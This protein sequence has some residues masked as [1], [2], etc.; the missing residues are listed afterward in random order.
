MDG[1]LRE[2]DLIVFI[3]LGEVSPKSQC[4]AHSP[5]IP[6]KI[7]MVLIQQFLFVKAKLVL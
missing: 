3:A 2:T 5:V 7:L 1:K 6:G 4:L